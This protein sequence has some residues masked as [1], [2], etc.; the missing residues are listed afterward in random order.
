LLNVKPLFL[1]AFWGL[2]FYFWDE[3]FNNRRFFS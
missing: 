3:H 2:F 1:F